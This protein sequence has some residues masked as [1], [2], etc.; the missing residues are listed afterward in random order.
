MCYGQTGSGKT[1]TMTGANETFQNRGL[2]PRAIQEVFREISELPDFA[3]NVKI[4]YLEIYNET[5]FDL[6]SGSSSS[7]KQLPMTIM[8]DEVGV[9]VVGLSQHIANN[10]EEALN[11]LFEVCAI[12]NRFLVGAFIRVFE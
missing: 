12:Q 4:S 1:F 10:E 8:E 6:L 2:I 3:I 7:G 5:L 9:K 11:M